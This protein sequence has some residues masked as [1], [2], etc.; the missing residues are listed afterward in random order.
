MGVCEEFGEKQIKKNNKN[1]KIQT[2]ENSLRIDLLEEG[3]KITQFTEMV[4]NQYYLNNYNVLGASPNFYSSKVYTKG[5][6]NI[7][8]GFYS[9]YENHLPIRLTPDIIWLLIVQGFAQH[10]NYNAEELRQKFVNFEGKKKLE[11]IINKYHSYKQMKS[12]D[13]EYL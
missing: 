2:E 11:I 12:E 9:A 8:Q 10:V 6:D 5:I 3:Q 7:L 1:I 4:E 13:Y